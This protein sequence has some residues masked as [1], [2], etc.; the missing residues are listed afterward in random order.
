MFVHLLTTVLFDG[1]IEA[2]FNSPFV[3]PVAGCL[4]ILGIAA[5]S[6]WARVRSQE[7]RSHE[8]LA[9]IAQGLPVGPEWEERDSVAMGADPS[10]ERVPFSGK[11]NDG[12][13]ARRAGVVLVSVGAGLF[14]FFFALTVILRV[15]QVLSGGAAG[16]I[17]LAIGIGFLVD[18]RTK[19]AEFERRFA[20][21]WYGPQTGAP[22]AQSAPMPPPPPAGM[23]PAQASD[24][25]PSSTLK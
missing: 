20:A 21:G 9:R 4:M 19:K 10:R 13:G 25:Q 23:T 12:S 18:A 14:A 2:V 8:R 1:G 22:A 6:I 3:V 24:W 17:P 7:I 5:T 16:L 15:P 11:M